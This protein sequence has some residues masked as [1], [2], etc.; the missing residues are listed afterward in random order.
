MS[1]QHGQPES[2]AWSIIGRLESVQTQRTVVD[3]VRGSRTVIARLCNLFQ[4]T[5][6]AHSILDPSY[7]RATTSN[8]DRYLLL[9]T[10]SYKTDI[11]TQVLLTIERRVSSQTI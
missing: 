4:E 9:T 7:P 2:M 8:N 1:R 3:A 10:R 11:S 5:G 6:H